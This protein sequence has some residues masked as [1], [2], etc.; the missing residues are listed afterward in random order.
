MLCLSGFE[1]YS[2]WVPLISDFNPSIGKTMLTSYQASTGSIKIV[3]RSCYRQILT[4]DLIWNLSH[5][6]L[7]TKL[8]RHL[9]TIT[10]WLISN[11]SFTL[12]LLSDLSPSLMWSNFLSPRRVWCVS[13]LWKVWCIKTLTPSQIITYKNC[14][15]PPP[16]AI[17]D[18]KM[19]P[20]PLQPLLD[21]VS[22]SIL[23]GI[24]F[25]SYIRY[26]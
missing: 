6:Y 15:P 18:F 7:G 17:T 9:N 11:P 16:L 14:N 25:I 5:E 22:S 2:R 26:R 12:N 24:D 13:K 1:L 19:H 4:A 23:I 21:E 10:P 8:L 20:L 3:Y